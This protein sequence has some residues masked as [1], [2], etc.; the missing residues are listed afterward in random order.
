M[1]QRL[2]QLDADLAGAKTAPAAAPEC[3]ARLVQLETQ[4]QAALAAAEQA[5]ERLREVLASRTWRCGIRLAR[6]PA[7]RLADRVLRALGR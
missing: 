5:R 1:L 2:V 7:G 4:L 6:T 3:P